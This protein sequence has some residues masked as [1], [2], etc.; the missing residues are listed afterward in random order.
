MPDQASN[1]TE[2]QNRFLRKAE[3]LQLTRLSDSSLY[4]KIS[5]GEF[6]Q[7][8]KMGPRIPC[9]LECEVS[10]W[11]NARIAERASSRE[12]AA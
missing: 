6:P 9:W 10:A 5:A 7:P 3:V 1:A 11:I 12:A 8:V 2:N 4:R